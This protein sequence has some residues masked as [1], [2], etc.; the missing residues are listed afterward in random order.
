MYSFMNI[1]RLHAICSYG[2]EYI[3]IIPFSHSIVLNTH[4]NLVK[5]L[6]HKTCENDIFIGPCGNRT[7]HLK[8]QIRK[9]RQFLYSYST[10][11]IYTF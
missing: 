6:C 8:L 11:T 4:V 9:N 10:K 1:N 2:M 7:A 5:T 3:E